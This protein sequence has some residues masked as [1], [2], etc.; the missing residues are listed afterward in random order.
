MFAVVEKGGKQYKVSVGSVINVEKL[1][2]KVGDEVILDNVLLVSKDD[3]VLIGKPYVDGVKIMAQVLKQDKYPKVTV[4]KFKRKKHY[5]R[6]Y[7]H[8]QPFTQL[9]I[10]EI[11]IP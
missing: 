2:A 10:K 5:R 7:G 4:F 1:D 3:E 6:K 9:S 8:R 11:I